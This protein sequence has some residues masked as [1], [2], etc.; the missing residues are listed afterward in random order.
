MVLLITTPNIVAALHALSPSAR[1]Q[2]N[3]A[4]TPPEVGAPISHDEVISL[5]RAFTNPQQQEEKNHQGGGNGDRGG[6]KRYTLNELL[7]GSGVYMPPP[8]PKAEPVRLSFYTTV[9]ESRRE[10]RAN[11]K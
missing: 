8:A 10:G 7:R 4:Q 3:L 6:G 1:E 5:A 9:S 11:N 2:L